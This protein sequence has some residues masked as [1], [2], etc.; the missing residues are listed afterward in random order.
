MKKLVFNVLIFAL[1][2]LSYGFAQ[3][4]LLNAKVP[5]EVGQLNEQQIEADNA[6]PIEYGFVDDRDVIWSKT[7]WEI[8]DLDE[9]INFP[10]Y[11]PTKNN[12]YLS[13]N[14]QSLFRV[15]MD[16]I[17]EGNITSLR[18]VQFA[19]F[20]SKEFY[21]EDRERTPINFGDNH[22]FNFYFDPRL[23]GNY[24]KITEEEFFKP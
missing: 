15:L 3:S 17:Q 21:Y 24:Y 9:R 22:I 14:R 19:Q 18:F 12:G 4:N 7:I 13:S 16:N 1:L 10:F 8:I 20:K 5:Q 2:G 11:Y 6:N 23:E